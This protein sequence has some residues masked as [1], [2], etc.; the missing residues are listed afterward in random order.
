MKV[1][2]VVGNRPQFIKAAAVSP[3]LRDAPRRGADP[4]RPA[5]RRRALGRVLRRARPAGARP[6]ARDRR[7]APTPPR[8]RGCWRRSS[9][10]LARGRARRRARLRRHQLDARRRAGRRPGGASRSPTSRRGCARSTAR[11]PRSSTACSPTTRARCC[12]APRQVAVDNLAAR[13]ASAGEVELVGD[14]MVDVALEVQP[15]ARASGPTS[16]RHAAS[17]PASTCSRPRT[18]PATSTTRRG[19]SG[20]SSCCWRCRCRWCCRSTRGRA[21]GCEP[22]GC[23]SGS[24]RRRAAASHPAARLLRVRPR[25]CATPRAVLTDSGGLQKEAYLAGVPCITLRPSTEWV[26]TVEHGWNV[27]VDLDREAALAALDARAAGR[28]PAA[29]RRRPRR[30]ARRRRSYTALA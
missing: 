5:L 8:P 20:S 18:A 24:Q 17:S 6:R 3:R 22:P 15:R 9:R 29:V 19:W 13:G 7:A 12:C 25:C 10:S 27:L 28:A 30:R 26:E 11:C 14:V 2:T 23:S 1:L 16:L 4:H 21:R